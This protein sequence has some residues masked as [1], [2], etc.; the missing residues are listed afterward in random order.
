MAK[1]TAKKRRGLRST[2]FAV[3]SR[4]AFPIHDKA[5]ARAALRLIGHARSEAERRAI[6]AKATRMLNR[7][8]R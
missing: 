8:G 6:H 2:Q 7:P 4:R 5:H 1:L 3:P